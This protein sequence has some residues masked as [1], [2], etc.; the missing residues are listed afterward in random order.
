[1]KAA[2]LRRAPDTGVSG[3]IAEGSLVH[4]AGAGFVFYAF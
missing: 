3:C 1:M 4:C 2:Q